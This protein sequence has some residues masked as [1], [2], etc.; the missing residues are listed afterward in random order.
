MK[1]FFRYFFKTIRIILGPPILL[2]NWITMP[3][4]VI[5]PEDAQKKLDKET[6]DM[7][8]Y[9]FKTC[10]FC[11]KVRREKKRL[12][13]NIETRDAQ[14]NQLHRSQLL[15]GGGNIKVPCLKTTN[16]Q[17]EEVWMYE[18]N[19]IIQHLQEKYSVH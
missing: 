2:I 1:L 17:G 7:I 9:Q 3:K 12:S 15:E 6:Q 14:R 4:G 10:P 19:Q 5:R 18:S 16:D 13:L 11:I 8:L